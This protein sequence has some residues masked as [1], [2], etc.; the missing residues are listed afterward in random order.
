MRALI[1]ALSLVVIAAQATSA[2]SVVEVMDVRPSSSNVQ[3]TVLKNGAPQPNATLVV[4]FQKDGQ[5]V[6]PAL[7]TDSA[8]RAELRNLIV[9]TYCIAATADETLG[10]KLC[11]A[12]S[13]ARD[14]KRS[15]FSLSLA[16]QSP[17]PPTF[18]EQLEQT[19]KSAPEIRTRVFEGIVTDVAGGHIPHTWIAVYAQHSNERSSIIRLVADQEGRFSAPLNPGLYTAAFQLPGFK[20]RLLGFEVAPEEP[21][22][23]MSIVLHVGSCS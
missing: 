4:T 19:A 9:G 1:L 16:P 5:Q 6:G 12:V 22:K 2:C 8:G 23:A 21:K 14:R 15:D 17:P 13:N 7:T 11:L 18:A 3:L 20:T 10:A